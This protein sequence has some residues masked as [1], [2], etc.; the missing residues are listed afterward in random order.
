MQLPLVAPF[1]L[2]LILRDLANPGG[3]WPPSYTC[4]NLFG[5]HATS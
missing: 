1:L 5:E 4:K 3:T 2:P